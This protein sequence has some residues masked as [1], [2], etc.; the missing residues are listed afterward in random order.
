MVGR[1]DLPGQ[2][3]IIPD[4]TLK[5]ANAQVRLATAR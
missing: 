2:V 3:F 1:W 5:T 4:V